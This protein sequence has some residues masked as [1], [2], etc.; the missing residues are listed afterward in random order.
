MTTATETFNGY[1]NWETW[2]VALWL[3]NDEGLYQFARQF[4]HFGYE[5]LAVALAGIGLFETPDGASFTD[6]D[7]DVESLDEMLE[8][9]F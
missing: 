8:E 9:D 7:L 4:R 2:N 3:Q 6:S 1:A 5:R